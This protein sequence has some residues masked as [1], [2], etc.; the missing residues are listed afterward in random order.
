[1]IWKIKGQTRIL[2]KQ[3][4]NKHYNIIM[5]LKATTIK[6]NKSMHTIKKMDIFLQGWGCIIITWWAYLLITLWWCIL[7]CLWCLILMRFKELISFINRIWM[8]KLFIPELINPITNKK[9][10]KKTNII[11]RKLMVII[12]IRASSICRRLRSMLNNKHLLLK[13]YFSEME[14]VKLPRVKEVILLSKDL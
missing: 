12:I 6:C 8:I 10:L 3:C 9:L 13:I 7:A 2:E 5:H 4:L 11:S 1:V 14:M